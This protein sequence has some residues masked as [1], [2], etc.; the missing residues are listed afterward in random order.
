[1][2]R[3]NL[4]IAPSSLTIAGAGS[5]GC[6]LGGCLA[7]AGRDVTLLGRPDLMHAIALN[8][9]RV[10]DRDGRDHTLPGGRLQTT[11]DAATA[12]GRASLVL[13][14]VKSADTP[15]VAQLIAQHMPHG[16]TVVSLQ[17]GVGNTDVIARALGSSACIVAGMVPFNIVQTRD[18]GDVPHLHRATSGRVHIASGTPQLARTLD[19][20]GAAVVTHEDMSSVAWGKLVL[21]LNNAL[22]ALSGLPLRL[23]LADRRWRLI[24]AALAEEALLAMKASGIKP[25]RI[26]GVDPRMLPFG[27]RLPNALFR[28]VA[29]A[30]LAIDP[31]ARSSMWD[32]LQRRRPTEI[33]NLQGAV[34][35]LAAKTGTP[36]PVNARVRDLVRAAES[37]GKGAPGLA[38]DD[39][40]GGLLA[41]T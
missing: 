11:T 26:D 17:N 7:A 21:N 24:L 38:P 19:V 40:A 32:D 25:A 30:M 31:S 1:M 34:I 10:S 5:V 6:Y 2:A 39:V 8:G 16:G 23:E 15:A 13:V 20:P 9:L 37:S 28:V 35:A 33:A 41:L 4:S 36:V 18:A 22:N 29:R 3:G 14:T 12:L 27:L